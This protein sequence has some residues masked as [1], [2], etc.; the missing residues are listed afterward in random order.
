MLSQ[1]SRGS[2][3]LLAITLLL[4]AGTTF[5]FSLNHPITADLAMLH[6]SAWLINEKNFVLYRDIFDINF[7]APYLFHSLLGNWLGYEALPL[8]WIDFV[9]MALLGWAS[10]KIVSQLSKPAAITGF[11]LFC[12]L[13]WVNGGEYVLERDVLALIPAALAFA[14][15][16]GEKLSRNTVVLIGI[17]AAIACSMKPNTVV[18]V[19]VLLW[20][21]HS[22]HA[23]KKHT[24]IVLFLLTML[25]VALIPFSWVIA[26]SGLDSFIDIYRHYMPIYANSRYDLWHYSNSAERWKALLSQYA[27][28]GGIALL[29]SAPGLLWARL[30]HQHN[31]ALHKR[32]TQLAAITFAFT[33]YEVIAGKFWLNHMFP[34]AY[35]SFLCFA[36]LLTT[37]TEQ[38]A[39]WK[40]TVA[41]L[42]LIPCAGLGWS[43]ASW[44][45][46]LMRQAHQKEI[47]A[48]EDWR[49]R[50]VAN[51]LQAQHLQ[52]DDT[53][54]ML[55]M[56]GDGQAA[57]LMAKATSATRFLIDVPLWMQPDSQKIQALRQE[58]LQELQ[59]KNPVYIVYFEQFL[60]PGGGN[61]LKEFKPLYQWLTDNYEIAEQREAAYI[62]FRRKAA[63]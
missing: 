51:Y 9:L 34:S 54:Q 43:L 61:R 10:W 42:L 4:A 41:I 7:P 53:V 20:M 40:K 62:I 45:L 27:Q 18:M 35:W 48:P 63:H 15:A 31:K 47:A 8:R 13:Y 26:Q 39:T 57:L 2:Q 30:L 14:V 6:Y 17:L 12:L 32:I 44:S 60:H 11:S 3:W 56:A 52:A 24:A 36:L 33:L 1:I 5:F 49:A 58:F 50:Q 55:D 16:S 28:W 37:P 46:P 59:Q 38:S 19:P 29:L 21:L 22:S 23:L 25:F